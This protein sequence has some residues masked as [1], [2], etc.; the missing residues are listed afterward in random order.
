M[1][2]QLPLYTGTWLW[3]DDLNTR[4]LPLSDFPRKLYPSCQ[5]LT[6]YSFYLNVE[7]GK[8]LW[9]NFQRQPGCFVLASLQFYIPRFDIHASL[10]IFLLFSL[11]VV[12]VAYVVVAL[13]LI[14]AHKSI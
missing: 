4:C 14:A 8:A 12:V 10:R 2:E 11:L 1:L 5:H 7:D 6:Y 9:L 3:R 13:Y